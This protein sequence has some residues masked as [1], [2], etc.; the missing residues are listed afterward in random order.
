MEGPSS[1][2]K[3]DAE[4][5]ALERKLA[6]RL[7]AI[8]FI[9]IIGWTPFTFIAFSQ[10]IG[11]GKEISKYFSLLSM[12][13]CK[14]SSVAN[15]YLYGMRLPKFKKKIETLIPCCSNFNLLS[16]P[17]DELTVKRRTKTANSK[18][19]D[20]IEECPKHQTKP[21]TA[22]LLMMQENQASFE[23]IVTQERSF[24]F[25]GK[26]TSMLKIK[27]ANKYYKRRYSL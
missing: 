8:V 6:Q 9:W 3:A 24:L 21:E 11:Y 23:L 5:L 22:G 15:A 16:S 18:L 26:T 27:S 19:S 20:D 10:L 14:A 7:R 13:C 25:G 1:L 12:L 4:T 17:P 2:N